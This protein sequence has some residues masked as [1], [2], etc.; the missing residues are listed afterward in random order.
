MYRFFS[1]SRIELS[2]S[3][4]MNGIDALSK[5]NIFFIS[6][7]ETEKNL[8]K[9]NPD[10]QSVK[11]IKIYPQTLHITVQKAIPVAQLAVANGFFMLTK[12]NRIIAKRRDKIPHVP[13]LS[14]YQKLHFHEYE[15]GELLTKKDILL[16]VFFIHRFMQTGI[17]VNHVDIASLN[18]IVLF[19]DDKKYLFTVDKEKDEQFDAFDR[20]YQHMKVEGVEY[21]SLDMR[22]EKPIIKISK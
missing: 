21:N 10:I 22:F 19:A 1:V 15:T 3:D 2:G 11:V 12:D 14:Y 8:Y 4:H 7:P 17:V 5:K 20:I 6:I 18:M 16:S 13:I 9:N